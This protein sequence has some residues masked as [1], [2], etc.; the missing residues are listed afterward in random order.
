M[1]IDRALVL[2]FNQILKEVDAAI[3]LSSSW[4]NHPDT[5]QGV[6]DAGIDRFEER[7]LGKTSNFSG[8]DYYTDRGAE[9]LTWLMENQWRGRYVVLDDADEE[10][11]GEVE[12][13]VIRT[14]R[15]IGLTREHV[16][17]VVEFF[18]K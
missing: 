18:K 3:V 10:A 4:R 8:S 6:F 9:I 13:H 16:Q 17:Q 12:D 14:H 15:D 5:L 7:F 11:M 2:L 1:G